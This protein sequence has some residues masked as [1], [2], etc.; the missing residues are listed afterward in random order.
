MVLHYIKIST[1]YTELTFYCYASKTINT[2]HVS[3]L[4]LLQTQAMLSLQGHGW[5]S[6]DVQAHNVYNILAS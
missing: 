3:E 1:C 6:T 4:L 2:L 5:T